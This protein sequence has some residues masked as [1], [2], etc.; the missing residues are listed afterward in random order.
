MSKLH[1]RGSRVKAWAV[2]GSRTRGR[3]LHA[4]G[5]DGRAICRRAKVL[6]IVGVFCDVER[7]CS[8]CLRRRGVIRALYDLAS[9][10]AS[11]A[12]K[13]LETRPAVDA[14]GAGG[15]LGSVARD[16]S[17][18]QASPEKELAIAAAK[19]AETIRNNRPGRHRAYADMYADAHAQSRVVRCESCDAGTEWRAIADLARTGWT[20]RVAGLPPLLRWRCPEHTRAAHVNGHSVDGSHLEVRK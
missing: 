2:S 5:S 20:F 17:V 8:K 18:K 1:A 19:R 12:P 6:Q 15:E 3:V 14:A 7:V 16:S 11:D 13:Q 10:A 4:I 9:R